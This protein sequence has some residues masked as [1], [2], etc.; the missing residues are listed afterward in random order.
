MAKKQKRVPERAKWM[1]EQKGNKHI[2]DKIVWKR[3][4]NARTKKNEKKRAV[5]RLSAS[6]DL[7]NFEC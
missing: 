3:I 1:D 4:D 5:D 7:I 2:T 6:Q